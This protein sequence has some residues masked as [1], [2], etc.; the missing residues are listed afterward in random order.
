MTPATLAVLVF[1]G[2]ALSLSLVILAQARVATIGPSS[3]FRPPDPLPPMAGAIGKLATPSDPV[4]AADERRELA[5]AGLRHPNAFG[6]YLVARSLLA[7]FLPA[8]AAMAGLT[9][10]LEGVLPYAVLIVLA[11]IGYYL[12]RVI[13]RFVRDSRQG[14]IRSVLPDALDM[15]VSCLEAGMGLDQ[16]LMHVG[17]E[18][19][20]AAPELADELEILNGEL[21]AGLTRMVALARMDDRVGV[22][23][24]SSLVSVLGQAERYGSGIA[25]SVRAHA[26]MSRRRRLIDAERR[27][28]EALPRLTVVMVLCIL[29][30]LFIVLLG[31]V[32]IHVVLHV[33]P[34][35][36]GR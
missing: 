4:Q 2:V 34:M 23:E 11:G 36:E 20:P 16:A 17:R 5:R 18:I 28:A 24:I 21:Q 6:L 33:I 10:R 1:I 30:P 14:A 7:L 9:S 22:E 27:A 31:P 3:V 32:A 12:P 26:Q 8:I 15:L 13:V 35:L 19:A 25:E 29:P